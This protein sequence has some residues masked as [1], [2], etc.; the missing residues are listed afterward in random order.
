M[1]SLI[2]RFRVWL[3]LKLLGDRL[4][5][6]YT[7][8]IIPVRMEEVLEKAHSLTEEGEMK[9]LLA[10]KLAAKLMETDII[11]F[12]QYHPASYDTVYFKACAYTI[13][14][15]AAQTYLWRKRK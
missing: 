7:E 4:R 6:K 13:P 10:E 15:E 11:L 9:H 1:K 8:A 12:R 5:P 3:G 2:D 14:S